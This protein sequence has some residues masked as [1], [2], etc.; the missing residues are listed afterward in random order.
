[1]D[2]QKISNIR[3]IIILTEDF[4]YG[5]LLY[6]KYIKTSYSIGFFKILNLTP[7]K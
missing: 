5:L 2:I 7:C 6:I 4:L 1:M 3:V